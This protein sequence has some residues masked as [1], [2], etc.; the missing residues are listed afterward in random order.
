[1]VAKNQN[2]KDCIVKIIEKYPFVKDIFKD[3]DQAGGKILLVGG[4]VRD[5][6]LG[7]EAK[8]LDFE[9]YHLHFEQLQNI[10]E[11]HGAVSLVGKSF[12][13]LRLFIFDADFS[14]PR[15]DSSGRKPEVSIDPNMPFEDSFRRRDLT[16][17]AMGIDANKYELID[18]F[19]GLIDLRAKLLRSPDLKLFVEDPLRLFR[20]MQFAGRLGFSVDHDLSEL[21]EK[22]DVAGVS[23]E[24]VEDEFEKLWMRSTKP[25]IGLRW[26][27]KIGRVEE[28]FPGINWS[29]TIYD[30][31]DCVA[32][33]KYE[34]SKLQLIFSW[35]AL[36]IHAEFVQELKVNIHNPIEREVTRSVSKIIGKYVLS[37]EVK[38][39]IATLVLY[40]RY[41]PQ[42]V[43]QDDVRLYKWLAWWL[44]K[45]SSMR[46]LYLFGIS[47]LDED[48]MK[49]FY[50]VSAVCGIIDGAEKPLL[51]GRDLLSY[52]QE[53]PELGKL[54]DE[55][56]RLQINK[57]ITSKEK[58]LDQL[59]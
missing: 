18:P 45:S 14:L 21:C 7:I 8:D 31:V 5:H 38:R 44:R 1:M 37:V 32:S 19:G 34:Q 29:D 3:I 25:S 28:F 59:H 13:V 23:R 11:K 4:A 2:V 52:A 15:K 12:G 57:S 40:S 10:L 53:G 16:V 55:A 26:L 39:V 24:R 54:V 42:I 50:S 58:L 46:E 20:V 43:E 27:D 17:N 51:T 9:V 49:N 6:F 41:I 33:K 22:M 30:V 47:F 48:K 36:F 35:A 56:Y